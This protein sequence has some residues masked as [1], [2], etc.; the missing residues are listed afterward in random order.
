[1]R[2]THRVVPGLLAG[3]MLLGGATGVF[4]ANGA[5][6]AARPHV[7]IEAGQVSNLTT[8][9]FTLT[10]TPKKTTVAPKTYQIALAATTKEHGTKLTTGSL[11][12]G[13]YAIVFGTKSTT[14]TAG[15][16]GTTSITARTVQYSTK[17]FAARTIRLM[18]LRL[19]IRQLQAAQHRLLNR[20]RVHA[21]RGTVSLATTTTS[22]FTIVT[23]AGKSFALTLTPNTKYYVNNIKQTAAP[24]FTNGETAVVRVKRNAATKS[25]VAL[26]ISVKTA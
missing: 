3:S 21:L 1:M 8:G 24:T 18:R 13:E 7:V 23:K 26:A 25:L 2:L 16:T 10:W 4:A 20:G 22:Q 6:H 9:G 14:A 15:T 12:N 19:R 5:T 17:A 11:A